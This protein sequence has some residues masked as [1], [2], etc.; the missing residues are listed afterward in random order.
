VP[1]KFTCGIS[2]ASVTLDGT[3]TATAAVTIGTVANTSVPPLLRIPKLPRSPA[4]LFVVL[5]AVLLLFFAAR[6]AIDRKP[7]RVL[8]AA[9]VLLLAMGLGSC[10]GGSDSSGAPGSSMGLHREF[11][12]LPCRELPPRLP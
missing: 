11:I 8:L 1:A 9:S 4:N 6:L 10:G 5:L 3:R 2:P 7:R 12:Q